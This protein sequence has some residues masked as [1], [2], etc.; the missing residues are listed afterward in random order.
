M[1][2]Y[3]NK[4]ILWLDG[5]I[6]RELEFVPDKVNVISGGSSTGKSAILQIIDYCLFAS[7]SKIPESVINENALWYGINITINEKI[8]TICRKAL[9]QGA[10]SNDYCFSSLGVIPDLPAYSTPFGHPVQRDPATCS[11]MIRPG[12]SER[13]DARI[14]G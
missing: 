4:I 12:Q 10:S 13:S 1:K 7:K 14:S 6:K 11:T 3:F 9:S 5:N 2:F 8:Y